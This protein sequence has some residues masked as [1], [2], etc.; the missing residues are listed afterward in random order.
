MGALKLIMALSLAAFGLHYVST[1]H[2]LPAGETSADSNIGFVAL[3]VAD[4]PSMAEVLVVAAENCPR[5][6]GQRADHLAEQLASSGIRAARVHE[7]GFNVTDPSDAVLMN[8]IMNGKLPIV[9]VRGRVKA[10]PKLEEVIAEYNA[11]R[12]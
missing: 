9:V 8:S 7:I 5:E 12:R 11:P 1:G 6:E 4:G 3:P 2:W 10:N